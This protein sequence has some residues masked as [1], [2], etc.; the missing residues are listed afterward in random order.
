MKKDVC[1]YSYDN[2]MY[3]CLDAD[4]P[5]ILC[6]VFTMPRTWNTKTK[7]VYNT[8]GKRCYKTHYFYSKGKAI[9]ANLPTNSSVALNTP[10]GRGG[11]LTLKIHRAIKWSVDRYR[12]KVDWYLKADDDAYFIIENL[13]SYLRRFSLDKP[14]LIGKNNLVHETQKGWVSG[15]AGYL[16]NTMAV[17]LLLNGSRAHPKECNP[18]RIDDVDISDCMRAYKIYITDP[19]DENR[20]QRMHCNNPISILGKKN[21]ERQYWIEKGDF[22]FGNDKVCER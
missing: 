22:S 8:W 16:L 5:R 6:M 11:R 13:Q 21:R 20:R 9:P 4:F 3:I 12:D 1:I 7:A 19:R 10:E 17:D 18:H 2:N 14:Y 15:G